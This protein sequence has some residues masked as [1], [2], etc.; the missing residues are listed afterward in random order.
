[1]HI[2]YHSDEE[3]VSMKKRTFPT[4]IRPVAAILAFTLA[5]FTLCIGVPL[6]NAP[7]QSANTASLAK[8]ITVVLDAGHGGEDGGAVSSGGLIEKEVNLKITLLLAQ[9]LRANG[10]GVILTREK[11]ELLY[12]KSANYQGRKKVL[13]LAKRKEIAEETEN[14][15][16]ISIHMNTHPI[17]SCRGLQV[18]YSQNDP[19]SKDL[20]ESIQKSTKALLQPENDRGVKA[21][22]SNIYLLHRLEIPAVLIECGFLSNGEEAQLLG[23]E[24]YQKALA[25]SL[26][27]AITHSDFLNHT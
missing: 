9:M 25:L 19:L 7:T 6:Q 27:I 24:D 23:D 15:I 22:T 12:D 1:M 3:G 13:D 10:F 8:S 14:A 2:K 11:D 16:F 4:F 5:C 21:A 26:F 17:T 18:W 20:A